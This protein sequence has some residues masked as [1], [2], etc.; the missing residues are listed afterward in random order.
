MSTP[1][2]AIARYQPVLS[3]G[4]GTNTSLAL[5]DPLARK[6]SATVA[7]KSSG[8]SKLADPNER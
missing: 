5:H 1:T 8:E 4:N 6:H 7:T 2:T 3:D